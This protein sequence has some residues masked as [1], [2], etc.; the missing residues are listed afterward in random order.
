M[1]D[2]ERAHGTDRTLSNDI[3]LVHSLL[4]RKTPQS[5]A[6]RHL[7]QQQQARLQTW[8]DHARA[9]EDRITELEAEN[10]RLR[11]R[12]EIFGGHLPSCHLSTDGPCDCGFLHGMGLDG[13]HKSR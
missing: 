9:L 7:L 10:A 11:G 4:P 5:D 1:T 13:T 2:A 6:E 3:G 12:V 8:F